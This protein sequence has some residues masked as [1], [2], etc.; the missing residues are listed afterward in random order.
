MSLTKSNTRIL[1]GDI[2]ASNITGVLPVANGGTG[3]SAGNVVATGSTEPRSLSDRFA[4]S[5]NVKDFGAVGDGVTDDTSAIQAWASQ[6]GKLFLDSGSYAISS[7]IELASNHVEG[8][9]KLLWIG[10]TEGEML[11]F[12]VS[13]T[14]WKGG[15][16]DGNLLAKTGIRSIDVGG[17]DIEGVEIHGF[18]S[19]TGRA[20]GVQLEGAVGSRVSG[21]KIYDLFAVG[22][23]NPANAIG[24]SRAILGTHIDNL[25]SPHIFEE[26]II[27]DIWGEEGDGIQILLFNGSTYPMKSSAGSIIRRNRI[28]GCGRRAVKIQAS[29]VTVV[30]N[31]LAV[32]GGNPPSSQ[33]AILGIVV[34]NV[35]DGENCVVAR[36]VMRAASGFQVLAFAKGGST[37][38]LV[39]N[40]ASD[41]DIYGVS[42]SD[43]I[44]LDG[45]E[46]FSI[47]G[48][49]I[50]AG[51]RAMAVG[52]S[53]RGVIWD[54]RLISSVTDGT[55]PDINVVST[56]SELHVARNV[57]LG[58]SKDRLV[59][60]AAPKSIYSENV[61]M[62]DSGT[63][64]SVSGSIEA[65]VI[66]NVSTGLGDPAIASTN[67][68]RMSS[69]VNLGSGSGGFG[70][71]ILWAASDPTS[72]RANRKHKA[73]DICFSTSAGAT[74]GWRCQQSGTPGTWAAFS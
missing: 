34:L 8:L 1:E 23:G 14:E 43:V 3:S 15:E 38:Y 67:S 37:S 53:S 60:A 39:G 65:L 9:G 57:A 28:W 27:Y 6:T 5:V 13:G 33:A 69:M 56:C 7:R 10:T 36:N 22:D 44:F 71:G 40:V 24:P 29:D 70:A 21:C 66:D 50:R 55:N 58:G 2:D 72:S 51:R 62:R 41:N 49:R 45:Q 54:N 35:L 47:S 42:G 11:N 63:G 19:I 26:N 20:L 32:G 25:N 48:N 12:T 61:T 16:I 64:V 17:H 30:D 68:A 74:V 18:R 46:A 73:G 31:D 59:T 52:N 4:D